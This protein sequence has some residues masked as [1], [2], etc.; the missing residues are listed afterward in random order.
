MSSSLSPQVSVN[1]LKNG[2]P[3][4]PGVSTTTLLMAGPATRGPISSAQAITSSSQFSRVFGNPDSSSYS[5]ESAQG[6]FNNGGQVLYFT[7]VIHYYDLTVPTLSDTTSAYAAYASVTLT[8]FGGSVVKVSAIGPGSY[9]NGLSVSIAQENTKIG[10]TAA[11][12]PSGTVPQT[13]T[14]TPACASRINVGDTILVTDAI[15]TNLSA[16]RAYV[17]QKVGNIIYISTPPHVSFADIPSGSQVVLETFRL[18]VIENGVVTQ[19][20]I[21]GLRMCPLSPQYFV[22]VLNDGNI[23]NQITV[24]DL[25]NT[26][27]PL[28]ITG[29]TTKLVGDD[30]RPAAAGGTFLTGGLDGTAAITDADYIGVQS[31]KTG[32]YA[33]DQTKGALLV[34]PGLTSKTGLIGIQSYVDARQDLFAILDPPLGLSASAMALFKT[35]GD[36]SGSVPISSSNCAIY[37]PNIKI[38]DPI[39]GLP[40]VFPPSG[41][42]AG[43]YVRCDK[44]RNVGK[45]PAGT[46]DGKIVGAI[47]VETVLSPGDKDL[48]Y[49]ANVN[50]IEVTST[51]VCAMGSRTCAIGDEFNQINKQR[52]FLFIRQTFLTETQFVLF[53]NNDPTTRAAVSRVLRNF[54][55]KLWRQGVLVGATADQAYYVNCSESNNPPS[56]INSGKIKATVGA[57]VGT[58][59]EFLDIDL[60]Q[61]TASSVGQ[62][63]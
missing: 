26:G 40:S 19:G 43:T 18:S 7:R 34:V 38:S 13:V 42:M 14:V 27:S 4:L 25:Y 28:V 15:P 47:G 12:I 30:P 44:T 31:G 22:N 11:D 32:L 45:A 5:A 21:S 53:E 59:G 62:L 29:N 16:I 20:P 41:F 52:T 46:N 3:D 24:A 49:P 48:L 63:G 51:G 57:A 35:G 39:S 55:D 9:G 23:E 1:I 56:V 2:T 61:L 17:I 37:H 6:F 50:P 10:Q 54:M 60:Y 58:P 33:L 36:S 8:G